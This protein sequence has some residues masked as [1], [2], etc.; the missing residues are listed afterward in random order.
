MLSRPRRLRVFVPPETL[1]AT[2]PR[3]VRC[4]LIRLRIPKVS[5]PF[6]SSNSPLDPL[7]LDS[8]SSDR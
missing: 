5:G 1:P 6:F 3:L 8:L 2:D 7:L 4:A